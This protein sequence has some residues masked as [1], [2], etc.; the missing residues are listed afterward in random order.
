M[1]TNYDEVSE[2]RDFFYEN[3]IPQAT[4]MI[5]NEIK[6]PTGRIVVII[7]SDSRFIT[8]L[9]L[10]NSLINQYYKQL[11]YQYLKRD[12]SRDPDPAF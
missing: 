10:I 1:L 3:L 7:G 9:H 4:K 6:V 12:F 2:L 5:E 11:I 8:S